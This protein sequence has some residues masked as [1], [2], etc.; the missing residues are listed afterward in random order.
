MVK[1]IINDIK[2]LKPCVEATEAD[3]ILITNMF[4]TYRDNKEIV[5]YLSANMIGENKRIFI[6]TYRMI[7]FM[8]INPE[9]INAE[10]PF[11]IGQCCIYHKALRTAKRHRK[12][13][14]RYFNSEF[15]EKT[16]HMEGE[17][18]E[19]FEHMLDHING[20]PL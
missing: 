10:E 13:D 9:I 3:R 11:E 4:E 19:E 15:K 12:I 1:K 20:L 7:D 14:V 2:C 5:P 16:L 18:A 17:F 6:I 8:F